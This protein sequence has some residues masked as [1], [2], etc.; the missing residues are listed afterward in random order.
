MILWECQKSKYCVITFDEL[1]VLLLADCCLKLPLDEMSLF[2]WGT[3]IFTSCLN[4]WDE[5]WWFSS[6]RVF[7]LLS[8]SLFLFPQSFGRYVLW[9]SSDIFRTREPSLNFELRP[10]D[11]IIWRFQVQSR[12][13][14]SI[15]TGI[16]NSCTRLWLT[17]SEQATP[18]EKIKDV[19]RSSVKVAEFDKHLMKTGGNISRNVVEIIIKTKTVVWKP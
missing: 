9:P 17:E 1:I 18:M 5:A 15:N 2:P 6:L 4:F 14:A 12:L 19:V 7:G 10:K 16:L 8:S 11:T 3:K 13:Q